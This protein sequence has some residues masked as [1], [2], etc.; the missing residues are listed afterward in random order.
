MGITDLFV[1]SSVVPFDVQ[2]AR[3]RRTSAL[4]IPMFHSFSFSTENHEL[5]YMYF[6]TFK[7]LSLSEQQTIIILINVCSVH[8]YLYSIVWS[9]WYCEGIAVTENSEHGSNTMLYPIASSLINKRI[10]K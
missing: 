2:K 5:L 3:N 8:M 6:I 10:N 7:F 9:I 4:P 1:R